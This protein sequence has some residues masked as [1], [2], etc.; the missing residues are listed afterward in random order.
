M[1][2][3][4]PVCLAPGCLSLVSV[5]SV[6]DCQWLSVVV[7]GGDIVDR[8]RS[9]VGNQVQLDLP[10]LLQLTDGTVGSATDPCNWG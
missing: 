7:S 8:H 3:Y 6:S 2:L 5:G 9:S 4:L 10:Q 1:C